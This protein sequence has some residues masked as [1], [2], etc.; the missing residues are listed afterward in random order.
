MKIPNGKIPCAGA[1]NSLQAEHAPSKPLGGTDNGFACGACMHPRFSAQALLQGNETALW[2]LARLPCGDP[3]PSRCL[4]LVSLRPCGAA[5]VALRCRGNTHARHAFMETCGRKSTHRSSPSCS[6]H[7]SNASQVPACPGSPGSRMAPH[8]AL[9]NRQTVKNAQWRPLLS[10]S[11]SRWDPGNRAP[12][13]LAKST[14]RDS[15]RER[16]R[17]ERLTR[18]TNCPSPLFCARPR[19]A[20]LPLSLAVLPS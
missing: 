2:D 20:P 9:S 14:G 1:R 16:G 7:P 18:V 13:S 15:T 3:F 4:S 12:P 17:D 10:A 5:G 19:R 8:S 6:T 11:R